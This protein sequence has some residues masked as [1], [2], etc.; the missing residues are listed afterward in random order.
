MNDDHK[1]NVV[2]LAIFALAIVLVL[3]F[4]GVVGYI[5]HS[6][7]ELTA[8]SVQETKPIIYDRSN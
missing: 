4:V 5:M 2:A 7:N 3:T 6:A 8:Q 1:L